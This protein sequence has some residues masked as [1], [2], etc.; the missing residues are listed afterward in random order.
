MSAPNIDLDFGDRL[1]LAWEMV[2]MS[3]ENTDKFNQETVLCSAV[4][5]TTDEIDMDAW[6]VDNHPA[7]PDWVALVV[8]L[9]AI[10]RGGGNEEPAQ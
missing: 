3:I 5:W 10:A 8:D 2:N 9:T 1:L 4:C 7:T 6:D